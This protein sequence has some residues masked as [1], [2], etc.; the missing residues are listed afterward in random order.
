MTQQL[1]TMTSK[2]LSRYETINRIII[3][4]INGSEAA[5]QLCLS[6]RQVKRLKAKVIKDGPKG[7]IHGNRGRDSN[8]KI[9]PDIIENAKKY[10]RKKYYD[11]GPTFAKEKLYEIHGISLGVETVRQIMIAAKLWKPKQR[12]KNKEHRRWRQRKEYY[13][14]MEQFDGSYHDWFEGRAERCCLLASIDDATGKITKAKF[15]SDEGVI[16]VH[17]FWQEYVTRRGKPMNIYLDR[18][19]TYKQNQ[20][21][22]FDDPNCLT[23]FERAMEDL[24]IKIIH[25]YSP[26]A[27]GRVERLFSTLQDRLVKELR[28][29]NISTIEQANRFLE[30][31]IPKFNEKFAVLA[32]KKKDLHRKLNKIEKVNLDSI[33]AV[34]ETRVVHNDFT[35]GCKGV[36]YQLEENQPTLVCRKDRVVIEKRLDETTCISLRG[37]YLNFKELPI[38]P[39]KVKR[40][41][42]L[43]LANT[44]TRISH[45]PSINHPWRRSMI[46]SRKK[47]EQELVPLR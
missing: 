17:R 38:R 34:K 13:G 41:K 23:Q 25:A 43:A 11:F 42:I 37:K 40:V 31:F 29:A 7:L 16:P 46:F 24:S 30:I 5:R 32:Q 9:K 10:L 26:Q 3:K 22:V 33:F 39:E 15:D 44:K 20:K 4:H 21:S 6:A 36:W 47:V 14:E 18:Y 1:I 28:L 8:R 35:I 19:S 27:K 45:K 12:K 2:E